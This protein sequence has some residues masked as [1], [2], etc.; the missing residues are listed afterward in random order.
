MK[1]LATI[2]AA[3]LLIGSALAGTT[4]A[5][6]KALDH[7][8]TRH[9]VINVGLFVPTDDLK[10]AGVDTGFMASADYHFG[11]SDSMSGNTSWFAGLGA[12]FGSGD[13]DLDMTAF[14]VHVGLLFGFG[15]DGD[16]NPWA[17][18]LKGGLYK[19]DFKGDLVDDDDTGFG[20]SIGVRYRSSGANSLRFTG[21]WY[22]LP[23]VVS[24][25]KNNGW[26]FTVGFPV[27]G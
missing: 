11:R 15:K 4:S 2:L 12:M 19:V 20:G 21:G 8:A 17:V 26:F 16:E 24:G 3:S 25:A 7:D 18:E 5:K 13:D 10:D 6:N 1:K 14:G 22:F 9:W 23:N 27:G